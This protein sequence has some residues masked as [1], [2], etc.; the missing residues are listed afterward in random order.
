MVEGVCSERGNGTGAVF[1]FVFWGFLVFDSG[2]VVT[3]AY[4]GGVGVV[5]M[6]VDGSCASVSAKVMDLVGVFVRLGD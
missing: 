3:S 6:G 1:L 2:S 4:V 5:L